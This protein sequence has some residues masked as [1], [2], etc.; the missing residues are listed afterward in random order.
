MGIKIS[1]VV[2]AFQLWGLESWYTEF[3]P[4]LFANRFRVKEVSSYNLL[5]SESVAKSCKPTS[6]QCDCNV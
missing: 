3:H 6:S 1:I 5:N 4:M 2:V